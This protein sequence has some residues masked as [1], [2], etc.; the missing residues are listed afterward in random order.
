MTDFSH[1]VALVTG[2]GRGLGLAYAEALAARGATV[3]DSG[4][5][6]DG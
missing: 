2:A 4:A 5:G 6:A 1:R 3:Q